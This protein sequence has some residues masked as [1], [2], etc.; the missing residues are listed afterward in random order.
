[1][2]FL[3]IFLGIIILLAVLVWLG[4]KLKP[5]AFAAYPYQQPEL[6]TLPLPK[7]LPMPVEKYFRQRYGDNVPLIKTAVITG[8]GSMRMNGIRL[9]WRFRLTHETGQNYRH[10][11]ETT[12]FGIPL[13]K[14]NEYYVD[15][16]ER[17]EMPW[18]I[19]ENNAKLD[20]GGLL[21]MWA[22]SMMWMPAI[23]VTDP[24]V[25]WEAVDD[26]SA[27]LVVPFDGKEERFLVRFSQ[28]ST[29]IVY[30]EV[31]RY[32]NGDGEKILWI[33]GTW[34]DQGSPWAEFN[35][36]DIRFNVPV[37]VHTRGQ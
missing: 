14:V 28:D 10:Y 6:E 12:F 33:N 17:M 7:N 23:L 19:M 16:K 5:A 18:G 36:E 30:W 34:F 27:F 21:G 13:M 9:P 20:Q 24:Q 11:I 26:E 2:K 25:R 37:D 15:K 8:R 35:A 29:R 32:R 22:E 1:M 3:S 4:L 31:M